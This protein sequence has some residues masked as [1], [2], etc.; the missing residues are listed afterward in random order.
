MMA[1][2]DRKQKPILNRKGYLSW[3]LQ[4]GGSM[5]I[6]VQCEDLVDVMCRSLDQI[7]RMGIGLASVSADAAS[8][9]L[10]LVLADPCP[11][12]ALTLSA[13]IATMEGASL[14]GATDPARHG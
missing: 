14:A 1:F 7:R 8:G 10:D 4:K 12:L 13:R 11:R 6:S 2:C 5:H 3:H 9:R